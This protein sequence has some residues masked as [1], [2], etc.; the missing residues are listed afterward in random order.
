VEQ[1]RF[2]FDV[3]AMERGEQVLKAELRVFKLRRRRVAR[4]ADPQ[5]FCKVSGK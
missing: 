3:S 5:H 2:F 4:R 1:D